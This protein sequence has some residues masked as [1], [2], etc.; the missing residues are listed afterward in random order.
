MSSTYRVGVVGCGGMGH[1][2]ADVYRENDRTEVVAAADLNDTTLAAFAEKYGVEATYEDYA[3]MVAAEDIDLVSVCTW[4]STHAD[5]TVAAA[6]AGAHV[7]CEKPMSTSL[8]A[9]EAMI[10]AVERNDVK[11]TI[12]HQ[13]RFDPVHKKARELVADGVVGEPR[14]IET[15]ND[16]GLLNWGTHLVDMARYLLDDPDHEWAVGHLQRQTDRHERAQPIEDCCTGRVCFEDGARLT[17]ETDMPGPGSRDGGLHVHCTE[18]TITVDLGTSVTVAGAGEQQEYAPESERSERAAYLDAMV[19]WMDGDREDHRCSGQRA[20][21]TMEILLSIYE[22][23]RRNEVIHAPL[24]TRANPLEV[25]VED[26]DLPTEHPGHYDIR[27][28]YTS[29]RDTD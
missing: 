24:G 11:L 1:T 2:H 13:R 9:A 12:S 19:E 29:V 22:S 23:V 21:Q 15:G 14:V 10:E 3:E 8:G 7:F 27:L 26:G 18:G 4:H 6:E 17:V 28:P 25:M 20:S 5:I 16:G